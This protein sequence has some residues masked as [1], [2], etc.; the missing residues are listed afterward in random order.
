MLLRI[1]ALEAHL[2]D[3][4]IGAGGTLAKAVDQ[5]CQVKMVAMSPSDYNSLSGEVQRSKAGALAEGQDAA[6]LL[7]ITDLEVLGFPALKV[8]FNDDMVKAIEK[9]ALGFQPD[10]ILT[11]WPHDTHQ[12]H[13]N[14][15]LATLAAARRYN[16]ILMYEPMMPGGRSYDAFRPQ[17]YVDISDHINRKLEALKA[18]VTEYEK[19]GEHWL[20]AVEARSKL[21]GY[22]MGRAFAEVFE[23]VRLEWRW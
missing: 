15:A 13:R 2:D 7:G 8:P 16:S 1:L 23:V 14:T 19:F 3:I 18:H 20:G 10:F 4:E 5:G 11:H 21:R 6:R 12:D 22:E 9:I 17:V